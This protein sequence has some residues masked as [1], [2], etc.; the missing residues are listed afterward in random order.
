VIL[1]RLLDLVIIS[2]P[3]V[4]PGGCSQS[5]GFFARPNPR[6]LVRPFPFHSQLVRL[7]TTRVATFQQPDVLQDEPMVV[8]ENVRPIVLPRPS[9][10]LP[11]A[12]I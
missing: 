11:S 8:L 12:Q 3:Q 1:V 2:P 5:F 4:C 9:K 6:L 7:P 10:V